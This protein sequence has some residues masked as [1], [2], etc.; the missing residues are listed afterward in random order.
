MLVKQIGRWSVYQGPIIDCDVHQEWTSQD[1]LLPYL[2]H[3]WREYVEGPG[4][5]GPISM[6]GSSDYSNPHGFDREDAFPDNP[7]WPGRFSGSLC[8]SNPPPG[9]AA[10]EI[11]GPAAPPR[12]C[13]VMISGNGIGVPFGHPLY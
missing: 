10:E 5:A 2:S 1:D 3:G 8:F 13:Q 7:E 9:R 6:D 4:K 12:L 11:R